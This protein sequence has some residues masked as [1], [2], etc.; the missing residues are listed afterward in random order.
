MWFTLYCCSATCRIEDDDGAP[1]PGGEPGWLARL[2]A[3]GQRAGQSL[4]G[5][6]G[7]GQAGDAG[8]AAPGQSGQPEGGL[9]IA[10]PRPPLPADPAQAP[11][12][13][14]VWRGKGPPG[15]AEGNWV[16]PQTG[17]W[18]H[19]DSTHHNRPHWDYHAPDGSDW[20]IWLDDGSMTPK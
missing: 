16:N 14:W 17:E 19:Y 10:P 5:R 4:T 6:G 18:L 9:A 11:A 7:S 12:P 15:S 1:P 2:R 20:R 8:G 3:L 13:G